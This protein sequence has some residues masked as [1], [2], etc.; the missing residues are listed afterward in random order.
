MAI[1][2]LSCSTICRPGVRSLGDDFASPHRGAPDERFYFTWRQLKRA[3]LK[4]GVSAAGAVGGTAAG[5]ALK[6]L[7]L[8]KAGDATSGAVS[9]VVVGQILMAVLGGAAAPDAAG[10]VAGMD[11]GTIIKDLVGGVVGGAVVMA[12]VGAIRNAMAK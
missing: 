12:I 8:G 4:S 2:R 9:V 11:I 5:T 3:T 7:S 6:D 1:R 10:A